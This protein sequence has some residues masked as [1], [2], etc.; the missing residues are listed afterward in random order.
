MQTRKVIDSALAVVFSSYA[1]KGRLNDLNELDG[2]NPFEFL[3][4]FELLPVVYQGEIASNLNEDLSPGWYY[5][6]NTGSV[7]YKSRYLEHNSYFG[8]ELIFE[9]R[10]LSGHFESAHDKFLQ[11]RFVERDQP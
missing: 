1:I 8:V 6:K 7:A 4:E 3:D 9:D 11:L 5:Y 10:N 2:G